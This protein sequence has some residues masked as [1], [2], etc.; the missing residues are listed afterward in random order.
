V[1]T[2]S[3]VP[4]IRKSRP[5]PES[6]V[7]ACTAAASAPSLSRRPTHRPAAIAAAS[8]TRRRFSARLRNIS[9]MQ[10][11]Y[12]RMVI[13]S[14]QIL[15]RLPENINLGWLHISVATLTKGFI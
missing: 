4:P 2:P 3:G 6:M 1:I 14:F 8:V 9:F 10:L 12:A 15:S 11:Q 7:F 5:T 13:L